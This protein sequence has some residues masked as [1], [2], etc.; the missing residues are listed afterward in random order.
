MKR[1]ASQLGYVTQLRWVLV[2]QLLLVA[3]VSSGLEPMKWVTLFPPSSAGLEP[4]GS[5]I[6]LKFSKETRSL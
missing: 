2:L 1:T 6:C 3:A 4:R 5:K